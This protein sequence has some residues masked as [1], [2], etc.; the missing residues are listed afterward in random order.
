MKK[1]NQMIK[2]LASISKNFMV[3]FFSVLLLHGLRGCLPPVPNVID[4]PMV[5]ES[6]TA[7][8]AD[9]TILEIGIA[10]LRSPFDRIIELDISSYGGS[11]MDGRRITNRMK[12][13]KASGY[14][15]Y[16]YT[17]KAF[18][19]GFHILQ[20]CD[21]RIGKP[22]AWYMQHRIHNGS[23]REAMEKEGISRERQRTLKFLELEMARVEAKKIGIP[24]S[25]WLFVTLY[26]YWV[27]NEQACKSN[28][29]DAY[30]KD[31]EIQ[32]CLNP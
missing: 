17:D 14:K 8:S 29:I 20:N 27:N 11:V 6:I 7:E 18:S 5:R 22:G 3:I 9:L 31:G 15:F 25:L 23:G 19:M 32:S 10:A 26:S 28:I 12:E 16:C 21:L 4:R 30:Y 24:L 2:N 13:L 1:L